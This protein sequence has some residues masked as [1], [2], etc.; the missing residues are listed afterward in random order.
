MGKTGTPIDP[1]AASVNSRSVSRPGHDT[2]DLVVNGARL[3]EAEVTDLSV[4]EKPLRSLALA[5]SPILLRGEA[6]DC[7]HVVER[8]HELGRRASLPLRRCEQPRAARALLAL[9]TPQ[10]A[11]NDEVTGTWALYGVAGWPQAAQAQLA[12]ALE[13]LDEGRLSGRLRHEDIPRVIVVVHVDDP[14]TE[15]LPDLSARLSYFKL[16]LDRATPA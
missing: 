10:P 14:P 5:D 15:L 9:A 4:L 1:A 7:R 3:A 13:A 6:T 2:V 12:A 8:L 11:A 16:R